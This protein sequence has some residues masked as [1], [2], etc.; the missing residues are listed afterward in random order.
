MLSV[1]MR[2]LIINRKGR[3]KLLEVMDM[4][5]AYIVVMASWVYTY[6]QTYQL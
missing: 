5:M 2:K 3:R 6:L 1:F 4:F